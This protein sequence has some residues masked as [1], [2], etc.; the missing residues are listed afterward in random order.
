[1]NGKRDFRTGVGRSRRNVS[2]AVLT[3]LLLGPLL[4]GCAGGTAPPPATDLNR[5]DAAEVKRG[6][7]MSWAVDAAPSTLNVHQTDAGEAAR[8]VAGA[9]LPVLFPLD[10]K[11]RPHLNPDYLR[12][13]EVTDTEPRQVVTYRLNPKARWSDGTPI[14][15][16]D[17]AGQWKALNGEN[18]AYW[19]QAEPGYSAISSVRPGRG[20]HTVK[21]EFR[22]P[23]T[24]WRALFS[25][26]YPAAAT[27][28]PK[29]FNDGLRS[30]IPL[31]AG[32]FQLADRKQTAAVRTAAHAAARTAVAQAGT[33]QTGAAQDSA[34]QAAAAPPA[35]TIT[36]VPNS[37]WWGTRP[38]LDSLSLKPMP[39]AERAA[40]LRAGTVDLA[41]LDLDA[42]GAAKRL[43]AVNADKRLSLHKAAG[44]A[45][46]QLTLNGGPGRPLAD[47]AVRRA[48]A[49]AIDRAKLAEAVNKPLGLDGYA[50][51]NHLLM[52]TQEGY[53]D[54]SAAL[55]TVTSGKQQ[56]LA[57]KS[58]DGGPLRLKLLVREGSPQGAAVARGVRRMLKEAGVRVETKTVSGKSYFTDHVAEGDFD[59]AVFNWPATAFPLAQARTLYAK[60]R[61]G[62]D[63][64]VDVGSNYARTGTD[65]IDLLFAKAGGELDA[66]KSR[67][68]SD[69]LDAR[70]WRAAH[71]LPLYQK[72]EAVVTRKGVAN[73]GAFGMAAPDFTT[74]G[75]R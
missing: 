39:Q 69:V 14:T 20:G 4:G 72:P 17:F 35:G 52:G 66:E 12:S 21:V 13:A 70:I 6:A 40:A 5:T 48:V 32:P 56:V 53:R 33:K 60:P 42:P 50:P 65:E 75:F 15:A 62:V 57:A 8:L 47:P 16:A 51:G 38:K 45:W 11:G 63:G 71:S 49:R 61:A 41:A 18:A 22:K 54:N 68:L 28:S 43:Q 1:L 26:L 24:E 29:A 9:T 10:G 23:F 34:V 46:T 64:T 74:I 67:E 27:A 31:S 59:L 36:L 44:A 58:A 7:A 25:P 73:A 37:R 19:S 30:S 3:G 2:A 55:G